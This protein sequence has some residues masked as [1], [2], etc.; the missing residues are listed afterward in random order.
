MTPDELKNLNAGQVYQKW[1]DEQVSVEEWNH[2]ADQW[3]KTHI[4][5]MPFLREYEE[6]TD[7]IV[8]FLGFVWPEG[9]TDRLFA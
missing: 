8:N 1:L 2:Y 6:N 9:C 4:S 7:R 3:N 5:K